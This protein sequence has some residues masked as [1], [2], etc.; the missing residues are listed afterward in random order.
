MKAKQFSLYYH[1]CNVSI[2]L[3]ECLWGIFLILSLFSLT[4]S[5]M[6][7]IQLSIYVYVNRLWYVIELYNVQTNAY[8][9]NIC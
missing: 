1:Q 8:I 4:Y 9:Y 3:I 7:Q 2:I 6:D 5:I